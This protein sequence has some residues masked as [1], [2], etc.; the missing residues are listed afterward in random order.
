M[1][2][3]NYFTVKEFSIA[4]HAKAFPMDYY[5]GDLNG[6]GK[7]DLLVTYFY[8]PLKNAAIPA[9]ILL[10]DGH[11]A[12]AKAP[13]TFVS[14]GVLK[15]VWGRQIVAADF[16]G[17]GR[18]DIF[19]A[20]HGYDADP[21]PGAHNSLLLSKSGGKFVNATSSLPNFTDFSHSA[22]AADIDGDGDVDIY[23]DNY[24]GFVGWNGSATTDEAHYLLVNDG[25]G[26]FSVS[27]K[28]PA[29]MVAG[30]YNSPST[31]FLDYDGDRDQDLL[32]SPDST[33]TQS[34]RVLLNDGHGD[35]SGAEASFKIKSYSAHDAVVDVVSQ[36]INGDGRKDLVF[37]IAVNNYA[38]GRIAVFINYGNGSYVEET[39]AR[40]DKP[41]TG[42]WV[43][44]NKLVDLN[45]DGYLD[46][47]E[48]SAGNKPVAPIL[49]NDGS[50]SFIRLPST[51]TDGYDAF[52]G[53][54]RDDR[55]LVG[56]F[57]RDGRADLMTYRYQDGSKD[58][59]AV[60]L[61]RDPG[62]T[63]TGTSRADALVGDSSAETLS[64]L[65][66]SDVLFGGRGADTLDGG[67][68]NDKLV[69][70]PGKDKLLG[71]AGSDLLVGGT[72]RDVLTGGSGRDIFDFNTLSDTGKTASTRDVITDFAHG[73]DVIDLRTID[74]STVLKG[75]N[76]FVWRGTASFTT[77]S[78][79]ELR[80]EKLNNPGTAN[81]K[82]I[83]FGDTDGDAATEFQI[84]L[85]GLVTLSKGD[86]HL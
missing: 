4:G 72:G 49:M 69:G 84:E 74:A 20:D 19:I 8:F 16:N 86:F 56:D 47:V 46:I 55:L 25:K 65:G 43:L 37:S 15:N 64:G 63:Q 32:I 39:A 61:H 18:K 54:D 21:F 26:H 73:T 28:L 62:S 79:G 51:L 29:D 17:D 36:D 35:F 80:Y 6:D 27:R 31:V 41:A 2:S 60:H 57:N 59:W 75:N 34:A 38:S 45:G 53:D 9:T 77:S 76:A 24:N 78:D 40:V 12:F 66:G 11:G 3:T 82:T 13:S 10:G 52:T 85:K 42:G 7:L 1:P 83:I 70:G 14:G 50:G 81:D 30:L 58:Y 48:T 22:A 44:R 23:V 71:G 5:V 68:G 33:R 67:A